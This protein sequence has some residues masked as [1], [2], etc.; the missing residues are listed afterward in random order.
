V[1]SQLDAVSRE[2]VVN[3]KDRT[4]PL[5]PGSSDEVI[6]ENI[7]TLRN[8]GKPEAQAVAIAMEHSKRNLKRDN[9]DDNLGMR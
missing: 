1:I 7:R 2:A 9:A 3:E 6:A 5:M 8:E 4:M